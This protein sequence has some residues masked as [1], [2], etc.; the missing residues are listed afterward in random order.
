MVMR[1]A[2]TM[3]LRHLAHAADVFD[4]VCVGET[5]VPVQ[6]MANVVAIENIRVLTKNVQPL[7]E[8]VG[9]GRFA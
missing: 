1:P 5:K 9:D 2:S 4:A 7:L 8:Q 6:P 3:S